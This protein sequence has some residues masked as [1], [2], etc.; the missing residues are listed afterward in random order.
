MRTESGAQPGLVAHVLLVVLALVIMLSAA[1][2][3]E[4]HGTA[5]LYASLARSIADSGDPF[6][7]FT[8]PQAYL[9]KPPLL[10]WI[11]AAFVKVLG[12]TSLA[13]T[14][15]VRLTGLLLVLLTYFLARRLFGTTVAWCAALVL[16]T[17]STFHHYATTI[18]MDALL[19]LGVLLAL[20]AW[21]H[22]RHRLAPGVFF[23]GL[24]IAILS[25]G[26]PGLLPLAVLPLYAW[27]SRAP[28]APPRYWCAGALV[29]LLPVAWYWFLIDANG[30]RVWQ[31]LAADIARGGQSSW[32]EH[33]Y[34]ALDAYVV[35]PF[36]RFWPGL[37][38]MFH[39]LWLTVR[40]LRDSQAEVRAGAQLL[41]SWIALV[42]I[43][44]VTKPDHD[45]RY[46]FLA[47]P[48][49]AVAGG[50]SVAHW[51]GTRSLQW[52]CA[53]IAALCLGLGLLG[54]RL[55]PDDRNEIAQI[56]QVLEE[57]LS[58]NAPVV[59]VGTNPNN[60]PGPRRQHNDVDWAHYYLGRE[61]SMRMFTRANPDELSEHPV[62]LVSRLV[63]SPQAYQQLELEELIAAE[64]VSL[65]RPRPRDKA[66][67]Q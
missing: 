64:E 39:G 6:G 23:V 19:T 14:L 35:R 3:R 37:P 13:A 21:L 44:S 11:T 15:A 22:G 51:L 52:L 31:E 65:V 58:E 30:A 66:L 59:F 32:R 50:L 25:K 60:R 16:V 45:I 1:H 55:E 41:L 47:L 33:W 53:V 17:N 48:A 67:S 18:R 62:L 40:R 56:R 20:V 57:V 42:I 36:L 26:P 7:V 10:M 4:V 2:T 9:L 49:L 38:F 5:A 34:S 27:T 28:L 63:R 29:L 8:G 46:L 61:A 54:T 43:V 24:S 12:P